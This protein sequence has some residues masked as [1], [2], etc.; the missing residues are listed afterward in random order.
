MALFAIG[1]LHFGSKV[2]KPMDIFG[3]NWKGHTQKIIDNWK[4]KIQEDDL[5]IIA[6][7][8]SWAMGLED[9]KYDLD[10]I[11]KLPGKKVIIKG[12]H[13][14]WWSSPAKLNKIY[15]NMYFIQN[16]YYAY[17]NTAICGVR[18]W[19]CPNEYKFD[20]HDQKIYERE[21]IRAK[22]SIEKARKDGFEDI[23]FVSHYPPSNDKFEDSGFTSLYEE[24]N[25]R[26]VIYGH[27]HGDDCNK[28]GLKG[29]KNNVEYI[30]V[31]C[32]YMDFDLI[33]ID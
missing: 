28:Y 32:D 13:D 10:M 22:L 18:G 14:Y 25:I 26:K 23:I 30:L 2:D 20:D 7:D 15:E 31:S 33:Q 6:G 3:D 9:A 8:T 29:I 5:V 12:N 1:D 16:D 27:L 21:L 4:A 17:G 19:L 24:N 11:D